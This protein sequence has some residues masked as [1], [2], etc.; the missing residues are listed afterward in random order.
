MGRFQLVLLSFLSQGLSFILCFV[1]QGLLPMLSS[2][3]KGCQDEAEKDEEEKGE[4]AH[5]HSGIR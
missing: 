2:K 3:H 1:S 5:L 4:W